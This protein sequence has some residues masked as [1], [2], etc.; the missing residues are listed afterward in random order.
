MKRPLV[1]V[2]TIVIGAAVACA[3]TSIQ[4]TDA[5]A[6][7]TFIAFTTDFASFRS[8]PSYH[9]DGPAEGTVPVDVLGPRTQYLSQLPGVGATA[10]P[11]GTM[12]VEARANGKF[13]A[14]AKRGGGF[15]APGA[16]DWEW[17]ELAEDA[18]AVSIIWR[19]VGPP[20]GDTYGGDPDGCNL[21]HKA[22]AAN[23]YVC[24]P[25]LQIGSL[26]Q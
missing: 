13:F 14:G 26:R 5:P 4:D 9:S 3:C 19:G 8:W 15:N 20:S 12:I 17:F 6:S 10:F 24:S 2:L 18:G 23:D 25:V 16:R 21:C 7:S 1:I 11:V 22:C